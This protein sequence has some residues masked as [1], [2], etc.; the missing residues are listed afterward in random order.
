[1]TRQVVL[2]LF[3]LAVQLASKKLALAAHPSVKLV[4]NNED[5]YIVLYIRHVKLKLPRGPKMQQT[6]QKGP[7]NCKKS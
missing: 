7:Q 6:L 5:F 2:N 3:L 1:M 4:R